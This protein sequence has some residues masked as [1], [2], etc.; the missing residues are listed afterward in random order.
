MKNKETVFRIAIVI[1]LVIALFIVIRTITDINQCWDSYNKQKYFM[2]YCEKISQ[3]P[4]LN[5]F[6]ESV[7]CYCEKNTERIYFDK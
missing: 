4:T 1:I 2:P 5:P 6:A 3:V 7:R